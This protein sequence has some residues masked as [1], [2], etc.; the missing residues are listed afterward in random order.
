MNFSIKNLNLKNYLYF[1]PLIT[2]KNLNLFKNNNF[3]N[4]FTTIFIFN[5]NYF[6]FQNNNFKNFLNRPILQTS[7]VYCSNKLNNPSLSIIENC[8]FFNIYTIGKGGALYSDLNTNISI[9]NCLFKLIIS[10]LDGGVIH[11]TNGNLTIFSSCFYLCKS[12]L[13]TNNYGGNILDSRYVNLNCNFT[14]SFLCWNSTLQVA[15]SNFRSYYGINQIFNYNT[16]NCIGTPNG[17][18]IGEFWYIKSNS[19]ISNCNCLDGYDTRCIC[20][21]QSSQRLYIYDS[22]FINNTISYILDD[23]LV[24]ATNCFF[25]FNS[26][27]TFR[28]TTLVNCFGDFSATGVTLIPYNLN[29]IKTNYCLYNLTSTNKF[30]KIQKVYKILFFYTFF[31]V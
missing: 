17:G 23:T 13:N 11:K 27:S 20:N 9:K 26:K 6:N 7:Y 8:F 22:N 24:T 1:S 25:F 31:Y 29:I 18:I 28:S 30:K 15:E 3:F 19:I 14:N 21:H 12:L 16:T 2:F 4:F 10:T 5:K